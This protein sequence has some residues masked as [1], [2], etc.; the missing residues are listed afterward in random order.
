MNLIF[1]LAWRNIWRNKKRSIITIVSVFIAV[2]LAIFTRTM[3]LGAYDN[4][5]KNI[6]NSYTGYIQIHKKGYWDEQTINNAF[7]YDKKLETTIKSVDGV[8][9]VIPRLQ[10]FAL[11][12]TGTLT[13]G[14]MIQGIDLKKENMLID[15][16][17]RIV[18][19]KL[20]SNNDTSVI[21]AKDLAEFFKKKVGDTVVFIGQ[22]YHG[23]TAAG[24]YPV[25][26]IINMKNPKLNRSL[27]F[28]PI[29]LAQNFNSADNLITHLVLVKDEKTEMSNI[30]HI[31]K[32]KLDLSKYEIMDWE[33]MLPEVK[34]TIQVDNVG[35]ILMIAILYMII[36]FGIL[37]TVLMMTE[38]RIFELGVMLAIGTK[39]GKLILM[40]VLESIFLSLTGVIAGAIAIAPIVYYFHV[41]PLVVPGPKG[42]A[43]KE[44]GFEPVIPFSTDWTI[45]T[46]HATIIFVVA[47]IAALYPIFK[48]I[49]LQ[50]VEAMKKI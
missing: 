19:G 18:K 2:A 38:E 48:I 3:Q 27:V 4:M 11:M 49:K 28:F 39:K 33:Q 35:G 25:S 8:E 26:G 45:F 37:G 47:L 7:E 21:L 13:K 16:N 15:W 20:F 5:I 29:K 17:S 40:L 43:L 6:V 34:E 36:S 46:T 1:K 41:N 30:I 14:V 50:P 32:N 9:E 10:T 23:M 24:K 44:F 31:L 12:S 22:G 42:D